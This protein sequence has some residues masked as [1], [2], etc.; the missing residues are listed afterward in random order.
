[1]TRAQKIIL[2]TRPDCH[3]CEL[4]HPMLEAGGIPWYPVDIESDLELSKK[5]GIRI[6]VLYRKD[7]NSELFWPFTAE[8]VNAFVEETV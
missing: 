2:Y 8:D 5:Y 1:M 3:L 7:T 6:P 4:V